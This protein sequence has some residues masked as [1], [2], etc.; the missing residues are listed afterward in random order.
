MICPAC[1]AS[2]GQVTI[3]KLGVVR[4]IECPKCQGVGR[5]CNRCGKNP[6]FCPCDDDDKTE[7]VKVVK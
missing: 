1:H 2:I 4:T 7:K 6:A 3:Y 5:T